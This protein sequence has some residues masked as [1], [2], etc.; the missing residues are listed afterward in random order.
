[1]LAMILSLFLVQGPGDPYGFKDYKDFYTHVE[2][3]GKGVLVVGIP[4]KY[5]GG[6]LRHCR[7]ESGFGGLADGEY[8]CWKE[9]GK[10][11][12]KP[13]AF[14]P[15]HLPKQPTG[16]M[17]GPPKRVFFYT[18]DKHELE[19][20]FDGTVRNLPNLVVWH[21]VQRGNRIP[22]Y[23]VL[24]IDDETGAPL[25]YFESA[26]VEVQPIARKVP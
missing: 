17:G 24:V 26:P 15:D 23:F 14:Q 5:V 8:E 4:D 7:V 22:R 13:M 2:R 6:Y 11:I 10:P 1:M 3:G 9:G 16:A 21:T 20:T 25:G 12:L 19:Y 18:L